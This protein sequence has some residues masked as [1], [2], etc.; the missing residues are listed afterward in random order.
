[1]PDGAF[2]SITIQAIQRF[3]HD[4]GARYPKAVASL[5]RGEG[6]LLAFFDFP[7]EHWIHLPTGNIIESPLATVRFR[8]RIDE[9]VQQSRTD[10]ASGWGT[11]VSDVTTLGDCLRHMRSATGVVSPCWAVRR[12]RLPDCRPSPANQEHGGL[13]RRVAV[14]SV[15]ITQRRRA[16]SGSRRRGRTVVPY[17]IL[18]APR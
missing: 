3:A 7:A 4:Y 1:M 5:R 11:N 6:E 16:A 14:V 12:R 15:P 17:R 9:Y 10:Q 8:Q 18:T 2:G 13:A